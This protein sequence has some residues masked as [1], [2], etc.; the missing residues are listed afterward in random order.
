MSTVV[1]KRRRRASA[2]KMYNRGAWKYAVPVFIPL[3]LLSVVP[4]VQAI[5]TAFTDQVAGLNVEIKFIGL[6]NFRRLLSDTMFWASFRIGIIF[7]GDIFLTIALPSGLR[8]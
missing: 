2:G 3:V 6:E 7:S 8:F 5:W 4:L 1:N